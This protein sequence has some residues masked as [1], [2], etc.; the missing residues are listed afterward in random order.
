[1]VWP[2]ITR[3]ARQ[4][5]EFVRNV[6][7]SVGG[8]QIKNKKDGSIVVPVP[9]GSSLPTVSGSEQF[10]R[11]GTLLALFGFSHHV[12]CSMYRTS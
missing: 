7:S 4:N 11:H 3:S 12:P 2:S 6:P 10:R 8:R 1:M 5:L 9:V